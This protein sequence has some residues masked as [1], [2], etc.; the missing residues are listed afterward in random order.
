[1]PPSEGGQARTNPAS[2]HNV[3]HDRPGILELSPLKDMDR[4]TSTLKERKDKNATSDS[5]D[6]AGYV[7]RK[8]HGKLRHRRRSYS[9]SE[10]DFSELEYREVSKDEVP[11]NPVI[12]HL[13][14]CFF[15]CFNQ[16]ESWYS[17][18]W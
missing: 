3:V 17:R 11:L 7:R 2:R 15:P 4:Y 9:R 16:F 14:E 8:R 1:M 6:S 10:S 13:Q 18:K 5:E 12:L